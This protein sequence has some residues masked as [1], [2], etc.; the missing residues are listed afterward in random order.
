MELSFESN[1]DYQRQAIQSVVDIFKGQEKNIDNLWQ[2]TS[3]NSLVSSVANVLSLPYDVLQD[4][5][6]K[7][8]IRNEVEQ[9]LI[10]NNGLNF[11]VE[12]ETGTGKTYVYLRTIYELN[13]NYNFKKFVIVV[14]SIPIKE[15]VLK[16]LQITHK[17]FQS[18][19]NNECLNFHVYDSKRPSMLRGFADNNNIEILVINIDSFTKDTNI[20][21]RPNDKLNGLIPLEFIK[22][23]NPIVIIDEPQNMETGVRT[24]A[25]ESLN[26]LCTLRYSATHKN[27]YNL[28]YSLNPVKA[29]DLG[30]VKQIEVDSVVDNNNMDAYIL[31]KSFK[32]NSKSI[33][34]KIEMNVQTTK[35]IERKEVTA[36]YGDSLFEKS[37][38]LPI[39][40]GYRI[41]SVDKGNGVVEFA[42]GKEIVLGQTLGGVTDEIMKYQIRET[43]IEHLDKK[44]R[45]KDIKIL[46]LFFIDR[47]ANYRTLDREKGKFAVWFEEIYKELTTKE[48]K[49]KQFCTEDIGTLHN[50]YFSQDKN[51][52]GVWKDTNGETKAD[53][54]TYNLIMKDKEKLLDLNEPLQFIF[55]HSA[56]REGWDNPNVFQICTLNETNSEMKKR[57]EIGRGLRLAVDSTGKRIYDKQINK[58]T[59]IANESYESFAKNLQNEIK[60]DC[61]IDFSDKIKNKAKRREIKYRKGFELDEKFKEIWEQIKYKTTYSVDYDTD[62]LIE[63]SA[64]KIKNIDIP[65]I[66]IKTTKAGIKISEKG[67]DGGVIKEQ[68]HKINSQYPV[69]ND[70]LATVRNKTNLTKST[71]YQIILKSGRIKDIFKNPQYFTD[72][73][74]NTINRVLKDLLLNGIEYN[75]LTNQFWEMTLFDDTNLQTYDNAVYEISNNSKTIYDKFIPID[76]NIESEFA[77]DCEYREDIKYY[78][79]L[80]AWFKIPTPIGQYNPDWALL[81]EGDKK[82]YFIAE[83]KGRDK[84]TGELRLSDSEKYKIQCA[85]KSYK[86]FDGV[87]YKVISKLEELVK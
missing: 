71:I 48:E 42:N 11:S 36:K 3:N 60:E 44:R 30:L 50:G 79:K 57:Q 47:V 35:G 43:I 17:H 73:V 39:Y 26:P 46:S 75:K 51:K 45:N 19:Y 37:N 49:Y 59:V 69:I 68:E 15:G 41:N 76:S 87:E 22:T 70:I 10:A 1:L 24:Q 65:T 16:N 7:I 6:N 61:G 85:S 77:K 78:F 21:N 29:Y 55:S 2:T 28:I 66:N 18:L 13:K 56:L 20:I 32:S 54:D 4:N 63:K 12:M 74:A 40:E 72:N 8:Q 81:F 84:Q 31:L 33:S 53:D 23:T 64:E 83:T 67:I 62:D 82:I 58:L 86:V 80:P 9:T 52:K 14:P 34:V 5:L 38:G 27:P 25:I